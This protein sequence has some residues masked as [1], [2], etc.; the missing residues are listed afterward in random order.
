MIGKKTILEHV[1]KSLLCKNRN[2]CGNCDSCRSSLLSHPDIISQGPSDSESSR[3]GIQYLLKRIHEKPLLSGTLV[4]F[5]ENVD[6]YSWE[7]VPLLLKALEDAPPYVHFL[8][9]ATRLESVLP[10]VRSRSQTRA[11]SPLTTARLG[12]LL[13]KKGYEKKDVDKVLDLAGGRPGLA[14]RLIEDEQLFN[15]YSEWHTKISGLGKMTIGQ[16]SSL[17][18]DL[19]KQGLT[20]EFLD[21][22]QGMLRDRIALMTGNHVQKMKELLGVLRRSR[23]AGAMLKSNVPPRL[24]LE[25]VFFISSPL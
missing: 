20:S 2:A 18:D 1:A 13:L 24:A 25:Y 11:L 3:A 19:D 4:V 23:E 17:A 10:T 8:V 6:E 7:T 12:A 15:Q 22:F 9:T 14:I 5:L 21:F 16:R